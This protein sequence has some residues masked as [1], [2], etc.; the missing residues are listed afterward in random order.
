MGRLRI[1]VLVFF[2]WSFTS[3]SV[4][5][6]DRNFLTLR[7]SLG[8]VFM[9]SSALLAK[10]GFD[11]RKEA[12]DLYRRYEVSS[13]PVEADHLYRRTTNRDVKSQVSWALSAAFALSGA[14]LLLSEEREAKSN[15]RPVF[16]AGAKESGFRIRPGLS[17]R[18][19][20]LGLKKIWV[21]F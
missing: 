20:V 9:G 17:R 12:N 15:E 10:K 21:F 19:M 2:F 14:R 7:R 5:A 11:L 18:G 3:Q 16:A 4:L 8:L 6:E 1:T 13:D